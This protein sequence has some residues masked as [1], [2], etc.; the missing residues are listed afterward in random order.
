MT[1]C[2]DTFIFVPRTLQESRQVVDDVK[3]DAEHLGDDRTHPG[4][5]DQCRH[6][7]CPAGVSSA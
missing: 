2:N 3:G 7:P 4:H 1:R 5:T 6:P